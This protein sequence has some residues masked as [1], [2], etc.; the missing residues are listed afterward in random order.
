MWNVETQQRGWEVLRSCNSKYEFV[1]Y[2]LPSMTCRTGRELP[3]MSILPSSCG[4]PELVYCYLF[5]VASATP[6]CALDR[7]WKFSM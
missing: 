1:S 2:E 3:P 6:K 5:M 7:L 4:E